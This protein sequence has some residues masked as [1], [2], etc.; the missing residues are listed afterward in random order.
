M[1]RTAG[2]TSQQ[3]KLPPVHPLYNDLMR[4]IQV[5]V[6]AALGKQPKGLYPLKQRA[7][8]VASFQAWLN[9]S[10]LLCG[11]AYV[12]SLFKEFATDCRLAAI[13]GTDVPRSRFTRMFHARAYHQIGRAFTAPR[14]EEQ[15]DILVQLS[16][17]GR[18][19]PKGRAGREGLKAQKE[20]LAALT[21]AHTPLPEGRREE[22]RSF[23]KGWC[24]AYLSSWSPQVEFPPTE[25]S[26]LES[27]RKSGG[28]ADYLRQQMQEAVGGVPRHV[29]RLTTYPTID[30]GVAERAHALLREKLVSNV[31][32]MVEEETYPLADVLTISE[33]GFKTR[34]VTKSPG[35][36]VALAHYLRRWMAPGLRRDP[37]VK[38]VLK[39]DHRAAIESLFRRVYD[40]V[41]NSV[42]EGDQMF[43]SADLKSATDLISAETYSALVEGILESKPGAAIPDWAKQVLRI[44]VGPQR[45]R[46]KDLGRHGLSKRGAL[47]GL[48]TTWPLLC[49]ANLAWWNIGNT[50]EQHAAP[51][52]RICGDDLAAK[53]TKGVME[54][55]ERN[56]TDSGAKFSSRAKHMK[57]LGGG[58]FTEEVFFTRLEETVTEGPL[59]RHQ[60]A[61]KHTVNRILQFH[62][63]SE[64]FPIRGILGT[65]KSDITGT[66]A[67]YWVA[68]GPGLEGMMIHR[69]EPARQ[70]ILRSFRAAHPEFYRRV[71]E[72][73]MNHLVHVPRQFGGFGIP[74]TT[75]WKFE[76]DQGTGARK[77]TLW[78]AK[79]LAHGTASGGD[80]T[81]L[82]RPWASTGTASQFRT[83]AGQQSWFGLNT[84]Y[85]VISA[86]GTPPPGTIPYPGTVAELQDRI[87]SN[88]ARDLF[89]MS[90]GFGER[91]AKRFHKSSWSVMR[92]LRSQLFKEQLSLAYGKGLWI[93]KGQAPPSFGTPLPDRQAVKAIADLEQGLGALDTPE[94]LFNQEDWGHLQT[95]LE[96][97]E[98]GR[99]AV[100]RPKRSDGLP[101]VGTISEVPL[102]D[103]PRR[104]WSPAHAVALKELLRTMASV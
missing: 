43:L 85:Q 83:L 57:E 78:A 17:M 71:K 20:H 23:A 29:K 48:P 79:A 27:S 24:D 2:T 3:A 55:Y 103:L 37:S 40:P 88:I 36:L 33:R 56:A 6:V 18:A 62:R 38:E 39:G 8:M 74:K 104:E 26:C 75:M 65:M 42:D 14:S 45:L 70:K 51:F 91:I 25:G 102:Y 95:V 82:S 64:A 81:A 90:E 7:P 16:H 69:D 63:W 80:L 60:T 84:R 5:G 53:A 92:Q 13:A 54:V 31:Q 58:V 12:V 19:L 76:I 98:K 4:V 47:M 49:L 96:E 89:F 34:I 28:L 97:I 9:R 41:G 87:E 68:I 46:Y 72:C 21:S 61:K 15:K 66:E 73:R 10:L 86:S 32:K 30:D 22:L 94:V 11:P 100:Y 77:I 67:P 44:C 101:V 35:S 50:G 52:V 59:R 1:S 93:S 99:R